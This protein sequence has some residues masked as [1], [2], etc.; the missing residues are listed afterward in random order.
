MQKTMV[1][2]RCRSCNARV[3]WMRSRQ[4]NLLLV[5][6]AT[7]DLSAKGPDRDLFNHHV[8]SS[9]FVTCPQADEWR[10]KSTAKKVGVGH[11]T[12]IPSKHYSGER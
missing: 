7:V 5:D 10:R 9:H 1:P 11:A 12:P 8:H 4:S 6:L 2:T 3:V